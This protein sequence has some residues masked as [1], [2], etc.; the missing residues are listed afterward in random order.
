VHFVNDEGR[1]YVERSHEQYDI[2]Q[3]PFT[4]TWAATGAGAFALTEN[5]LYTV[6]AWQTFIDHLS[7]RG[8]LSVTRWYLPPK[9]IEAY[10]LTALGAEALRRE[11]VADP[12]GH[13]VLVRSAETLPGISVA[14]L[15]V[16]KQPFSV[17]D[18]DLIDQVSREHGW[19]VVLAPGRP[20]LD[21]LFT[22]IVETDDVASIHLGYPADITPPTDD[23]PFFFQM[24]R[25]R[26]LFDRSLYGGAN[27]YAARPVL[28]LFSLSIA[29]IGL[30]A[31]C[32]VVPLALATSRRALGSNVP[33]VI[34]F[35]AIGLGFLLLEIAQ[36]QR[37]SL[38]LGHPTYSLSVVLFSLLLFSGLGSFASDGLVRVRPNPGVHLRQLWP[39]AGLLCVIV[40]FGVATPGIIDHFRGETTPLRITTAVALL[41]PMG[42]FMGMPFPLGMKVA[43]ARPEA[44]T[45]FFWGINGAT[46]VC[47]SVLA[48]AVSLGWGIS[49]AFWA[50]CLAYAVAAVA[51]GYAVLRP[52]P[53]VV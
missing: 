42:V 30:T 35:A 43:S 11:D 52:G 16:S 10:R 20:S 51:L 13:M 46:S 2:L 29:V 6:D 9:P 1:A 14:N 4:D 27:D 7:D 12:R 18:L 45:A 32:I 21:P 37:L 34:F 24:V 22:Q 23:R 47:A 3:I 40:A 19:T 38:F 26:D 17:A 8:I 5:G 33:L 31:L 50:G 28:V 15:L 49:M 53:S 48:V 25:F 41:A 39:L 44:P 36:M